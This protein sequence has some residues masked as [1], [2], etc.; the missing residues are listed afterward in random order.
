MFVLDDSAA[1]TV[2]PMPAFSADA[3]SA[4]M[5]WGGNSGHGGWGGGGVSKM[6]NCHAKG[7]RLCHKPTVHPCFLFVQDI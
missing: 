4:F 5:Q 3:G 1:H 6:P 2:C 7:W